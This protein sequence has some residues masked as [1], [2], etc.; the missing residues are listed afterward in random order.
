VKR[1]LKS[2]GRWLDRP[3]VRLS[4][5]LILFVTAIFELAETAV[6]ETIGADIGAHHGVILYAMSEA[7]RQIHR[8]TEGLG[9]ASEA[10]VKLEVSDEGRR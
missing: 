5:A 2:V 4:F 7:L 3:R 10:V 6:E 8:V 9:D 1:L